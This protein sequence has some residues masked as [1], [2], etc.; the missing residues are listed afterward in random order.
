MKIFLMVVNSPYIKENV[1]N[2]YDRL[3]C[4]HAFQK[5]CHPD[6]KAVC[7]DR[8]VSASLFGVYGKCRQ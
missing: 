2:L 7:A 5:E 8:N 4:L 6:R 1:N 3:Q